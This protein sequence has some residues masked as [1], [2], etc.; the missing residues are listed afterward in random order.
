MKKDKRIKCI[1]CKQPI[2]IDNWGGV[3]KEGFFCK[4][5]TCLIELQDL[6][7]QPGREKK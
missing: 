4:N 7:S 6:L 5:I 2:K 3:I 1:F